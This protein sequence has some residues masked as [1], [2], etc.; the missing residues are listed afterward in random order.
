ML[1]SSLGT[2][3]ARGNKTVVCQ[4]QEAGCTCVLRHR[5]GFVTI[6]SSYRFISV[7]IYFSSSAHPLVHLPLLKRRYIFIYT[8]R[9]SS[10]DFCVYTPTLQPPRNISMY[11]FRGFYCELIVSI[12]RRRT[13]PPTYPPLLKR[14]YIFRGSSCDLYPCCC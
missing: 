1:A 7:L 8:F 14:R 2:A 10:F 13:H 6:R 11:I 3:I 4:V 12:P 5:Y 9:A